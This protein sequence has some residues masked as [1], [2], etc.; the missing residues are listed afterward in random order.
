MNK[1]HIK[2]LL[3]L[4]FVFLASCTPIAKI[5][6]G[7]KN[8]ETYVPNDERVE[9][10]KPYFESTDNKVNIYAFKN[11]EGLKA[12]SDSVGIPRVFLHNILNDSVYV[13]NCHEDMLYDV[14]EINKNNF[15]D[16]L[17]ADKKEFVNLKN[18]IDTSAVLTYTENEIRKNNK[19]KVY[20][21]NGT[22]MGKTLRKKALPVT[23]TL[24]GV[25]E[26]IVVDVSIDGEKP[27][28]K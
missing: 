25:E 7:I 21:V 5:I 8:F 12:T 11:R 27:E 3:V 1:T 13:L 10:Y 17:L 28:N 23:K 16:I 24:E 22:F 9:Y 15:K 19:W 18:I 4:S 20:L 14:E 26:L 2:T 6:Y